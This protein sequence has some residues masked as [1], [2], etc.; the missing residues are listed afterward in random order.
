MW[1]YRDVVTWLYWEVS[2]PYLRLPKP[3]WTASENATKMAIG[4]RKKTA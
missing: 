2:K 1:R 3:C 4:P